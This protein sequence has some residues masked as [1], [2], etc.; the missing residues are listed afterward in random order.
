M[1]TT[2][3][4]RDESKL[5]AD[6]RLA[7][8]ARSDFLL[9]RINTGV[10]QVQGGKV[11]SAPNGFPDMIG[12]QHR[13]V[14]EHIRVETN[15]SLHEKQEWHAYGQAIAI[16]TKTVKGRMSDAQKAWRAQFEKVGGIYVLARDVRDVLEVL[17]PEPR[18]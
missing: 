1:K 11:R 3:R 7:V 9:T 18:S 5:L 17:G 13:R 10:F 2:P 15:F 6:I 8:G 12:T 14:L 4:K 16:E